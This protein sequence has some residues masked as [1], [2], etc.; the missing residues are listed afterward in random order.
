[1]KIDIA[2]ANWIEFLEIVNL[3]EMIAPVEVFLN[4]E[5]T[6]VSV[7]ASDK[8]KSIQYVIPSWTLFGATMEAEKDE[9][10]VIDPVEILSDM[11]KFKKSKEITVETSD[12]MMKIS[13]QLGNEIN[14]Y[15]K[16]KKN[17]VTIPADRVPKFDAD[18]RVLFKKRVKDED[19]N[20]S[21]KQGPADTL[22]LIDS[23]QVQL[24]VND[25]TK[26][27]KTEYVEF[28]FSDADGSFAKS[29]HM[30]TKAKTSK[31]YL[32]ATVDG[33]DIDFVLPKSFAALVSPFEGE[34][35]IQG[36]AESPG[37]VVKYEKVGKGDVIVV[38]MRQK[39]AKKA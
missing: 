19:G 2:P 14:Y 4:E 27:A 26:H 28:A 34:L 32:Q 11:V 16:D 9:S 6:Q 21:I 22:V 1:M 18:N 8:T 7:R 13:D 15:L 30:D 12:G 33:D 3:G 36:S 17:A 35:E 37:V 24:A 20:E 29:G 39:V 38:I 23:T 25:M 5:E 10:I 31:S